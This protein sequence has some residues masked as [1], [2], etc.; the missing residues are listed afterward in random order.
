MHENVPYLTIVFNEWLTVVK[1]LKY[2]LCCSHSYLKVP[3]QRNSAQN[4]KQKQVFTTKIWNAL[5]WGSLSKMPAIWIYSQP[6]I[7]KSIST[8]LSKPSLIEGVF[9]KWSSTKIQFSSEII[10]SPYSDFPGLTA[11]LNLLFKRSSN[12]TFLLMMS[13]EGKHVLG[14][15]LIWGQ[16]V[17]V[18]LSGRCRE[19]SEE[20]NMAEYKHQVE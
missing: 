10:T 20:D 18:W 7:R 8:S 1:P 9:F 16:F 2:H 15:Y 5:T 6:T 12:V 11:I 13:S 19:N 3:K 14:V 17:L 4:S